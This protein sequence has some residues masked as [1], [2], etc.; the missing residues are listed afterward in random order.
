MVY[1]NNCTKS[2]FGIQTIEKSIF[3]IV[4][5]ALC[6]YRLWPIFVSSSKTVAWWFH[7]HVTCGS[8]GDYL[9]ISR[10]GLKPISMY[11]K[12]N[13]LDQVRSSWNIIDNNTTNPWLRNNIIRCVSYCTHVLD[14]DFIETFQYCI[15]LKKER[16][17][18]LRSASPVRVKDYAE[19]T[20]QWRL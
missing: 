17:T 13:K 7:D 8:T 14:T 16:N 1:P 15:V 19:V 18:M 20:A 9:R 2:L 3:D 12:L 6:R 5:T 10:S 11:S 4:D